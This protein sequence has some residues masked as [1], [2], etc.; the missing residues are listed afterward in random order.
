MNSGKSNN[1]YGMAIRKTRSVEQVERRSGTKIEDKPCLYERITR[2]T[3]SGTAS[4]AALNFVA[5]ARPKPRPAIRDQRTG[6]SVSTNTTQA[7]KVK[8]M[9][10]SSMVSTVDKSER[11]NCEGVNETQY[12]D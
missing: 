6:L 10:K 5:R 11:C 4:G 3:N 8:V 1:A 12:A 2:A 9:K 7:K